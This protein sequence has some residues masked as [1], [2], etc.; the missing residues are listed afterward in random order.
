[1]GH[2]DG[3]GLTPPTKRS[4]SETLDTCPRLEGTSWLSICSS[5]RA[6]RL[7]SPVASRESVH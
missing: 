4:H 7:A 2:T 1:M 6:R 3:E 5:A